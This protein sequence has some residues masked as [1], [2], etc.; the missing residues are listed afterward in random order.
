[1]VARLADGTLFHVEFQAGGDGRLTWR[2]LEYYAPISEQNGGAPVTQLVLHLGERRAGRQIG[3]EHPNLR[4]SYAVR[5]LA[6]LDAGPLLASPAPED[7]AL[8][9]LCQTGRY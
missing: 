7:A 9:I 8:A 5:Y 4:F 2:M 6:D 1:M 3:I